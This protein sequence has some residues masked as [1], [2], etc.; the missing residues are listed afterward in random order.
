MND[1]TL[2]LII[3]TLTAG[4][5]SIILLIFTLYMEKRKKKSKEVR[6]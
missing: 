4:T 6:H 3:A 2:S 5:V 1:A